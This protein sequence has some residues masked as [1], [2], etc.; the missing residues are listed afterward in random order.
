[1][2]PDPATGFR[3]GDL[4]GLLSAESM[5]P[6][7]V[8]VTGTEFGARQLALFSSAMEGWN[9]LGS[10]ISTHLDA[11]ETYAAELNSLIFICH[12]AWWHTSLLPAFKR[13]ISVS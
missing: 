13:W 1:M 10:S 12:W 3:V 4:E 2:P 11:V 7:R 8:L 9:H 6:L 5:L